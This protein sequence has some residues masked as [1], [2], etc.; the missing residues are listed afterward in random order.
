MASTTVLSLARSSTAISS[1]RASVQLDHTG[2]PVGNPA[3]TEV[4]ECC[5]C[6]MKFCTCNCIATWK[7]SSGYRAWRSMRHK[8]KK[9]V[10]HR[11]FEWAILVI[12][13]ASSV[14][15]VRT[16]AVLTISGLTPLALLAITSLFK[17]PYW[18]CYV[19]HTKMQSILNTHVQTRVKGILLGAGANSIVNLF[20][21]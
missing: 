16:A 10:E 9:L 6:W 7:Q 12:I 17:E 18:R 4:Q 8:V 20:R 13:L 15:L 5:P 21:P 3:M 1:P 11:Y 19:H 2:K 14:T